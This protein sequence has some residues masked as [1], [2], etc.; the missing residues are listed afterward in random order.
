MSV[1]EYYAPGHALFGFGCIEG[2]RGEIRK[3]D[4]KKAMIVA[5]KKRL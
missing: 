5:P 4:L 2:I 1:F 3:R